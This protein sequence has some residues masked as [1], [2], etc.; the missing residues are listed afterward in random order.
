MKEDIKEMTSAEVNQLL[1]SGEYSGEYTP[2]GKFW[3][4][5]NDVYVGLDNS[6]G[7]CWTQDFRSKRACFKWLRGD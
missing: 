3:H 4:K 1:A 7:Y 5:E 2:I 6:D